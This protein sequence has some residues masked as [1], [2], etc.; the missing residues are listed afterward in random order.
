MNKCAFFAFVALALIATAS[1]WTAPSPPAGW[2]DWATF[3][4]EAQGTYKAVGY[5]STK[6]GPGPASPTDE[7]KFI[8]D[9]DNE[10]MHFDMGAGGGKG[11]ITRNGTYNLSPVAQ[12][13]TQMVCLATGGTYADQ[14]AHYA[15]QVYH[16]ATFR[17]SYG[18]V[19]KVYQGAVND[20]SSC[21]RPLAVHLT[22]D[23]VGHMTSFGVTYQLCPAPGQPLVME[24]AMQ[25]TGFVHGPQIA[26]QIPPVDPLCMP[27][28]VQNYCDLFYVHQ[29][30][31]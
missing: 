26:G 30:A 7:A 12:G 28:Y 23:G 6:P 4:W 24:Q 10:I 13:S 27:P 14:I 1:A 16:K 15:A 8:I 29:C 31:F 18:S 9:T 22:T 25:F 20:T 5:S 21:T 17:N 3:D 19:T 2:D 11:W